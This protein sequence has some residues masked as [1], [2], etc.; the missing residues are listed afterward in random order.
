MKLVSLTF[1]VAL[2]VALPARGDLSWTYV[3]IGGFPFYDSF[4]IDAKIPQVQG[5]KEKEKID[6]DGTGVSVAGSYAILPNWHLFLGYLYRDAEN[7]SVNLGTI[8]PIMPAGEGELPPSSVKVKGKAKLTEHTVTGGPGFNYRVGE[9]T[10]IVMR[11]GFVY[12]R[13]EIKTKANFSEE[14]FDPFTLSSTDDE[15]Q[16]GII[17]QGGVRSMV[18]DR[19][20]LFGQMSSTSLNLTEN[21]ILFDLGGRFDFTKWL[22]ATVSTG[23]GTDGFI[24]IFLG[25]R[26][27]RPP[28]D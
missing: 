26:L 13:P 24:S 21:T 20:E 2:L 27:S 17:G 4:E 14:G 16:V 15:A 11:L 1:V 25:A 12:S 6:F 9:R 22:A 19:I 10:D 8:E 7:D 3:E 23:V 18:T 28:A 5:G